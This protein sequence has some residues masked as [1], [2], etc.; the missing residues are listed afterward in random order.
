MRKQS[1]AEREK[2]NSTDRI[3]TERDADA[4]P[5]CKLQKAAAG[6]DGMGWDG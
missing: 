2:T 4:R 1:R 5:T 3:G 6:R